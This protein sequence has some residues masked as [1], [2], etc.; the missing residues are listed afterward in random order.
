[1]LG[2]MAV[3]FFRESPLLAYPL[4]ALACFVSVYFAWVLRTAL[5]NAAH[6]EAMARLPLDAPLAASRTRMDAEHTLTERAP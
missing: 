5:T 3:Q 6:Y 4:F 2:Y 1:M